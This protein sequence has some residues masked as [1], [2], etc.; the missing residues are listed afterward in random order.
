MTL[1]SESA[2]LAHRRPL[3]ERERFVAAQRAG[4]WAIISFDL[5]LF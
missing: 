5:T 1:S 3:N 2:T 4:E